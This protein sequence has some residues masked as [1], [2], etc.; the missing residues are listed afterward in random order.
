M[1]SKSRSKNQGN[2]YAAYMAEQRWAKNRRTK[3]KKLAKVHPDNAQIATALANIKY[4]RKT[5]GGNTWSH[6]ERTTATLVKE[7]EGHFDKKILLLERWVIPNKPNTHKHEERKNHDPRGWFSLQARAH[8][9]QGVA[10]WN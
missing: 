9:G 10:T 4:R 5:P 3:L 6:S 2:K 7:F 1:A 8:N